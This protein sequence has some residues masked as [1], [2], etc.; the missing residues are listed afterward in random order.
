MIRG[1]DHRPSRGQ[2][3]SADHLDSINGPYQAAEDTANLFVSLEKRRNETLL[4]A[5]PRTDAIWD[6][7]CDFNRKS[8]ALPLEY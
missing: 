3:I 5:E 6:W 8:R 4:R 7:C 2:A 1:D